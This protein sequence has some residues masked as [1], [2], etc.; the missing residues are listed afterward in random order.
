MHIVLAKLGLA[1][2]MGGGGDEHFLRM[3]GRGGGEK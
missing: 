2:E 3:W 1:N